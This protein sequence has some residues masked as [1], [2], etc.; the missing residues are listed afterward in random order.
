MVP[1]HGA[2]G[3]IPGQGIR[4]HVT[5]KVCMLQLKILHITTKIWCSQ[6][7]S[8]SL[9]H[10]QL[11]A[12]PWTVAHQAPVHGISQARILE[13]LAISYSWGSS[14]P[15]DQNCSSYCVS[16]IPGW[17]TREAWGWEEGLWSL[18]LNI[19]F[20]WLLPAGKF[21]STHI[22]QREELR[23]NHQIYFFKIA[24]TIFDR[25]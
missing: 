4:S 24:Y 18:Y 8:Q 2:W 20:S 10:V 15:R 14:G 11:F 1:K 25:Y 16:Y 6:K 22:L 23:Q 3:S 13:S 5:T 9:R 17:A 21:R 12:T 7:N 19:H